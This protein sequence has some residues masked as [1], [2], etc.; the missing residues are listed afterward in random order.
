MGC[1]WLEK[2]NLLVLADEANYAEF[3]TIK[4]AR[5]KIWKNTTA[6]SQCLL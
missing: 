6:I 2:N 4:T 1:I 5:E 3:K